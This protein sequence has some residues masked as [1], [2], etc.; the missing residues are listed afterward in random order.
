L[1]A[2]SIVTVLVILISFKLHNLDED[3]LLSFLIL[4][5]KL[6][7]SLLVVLAS[8]SDVFLVAE[9]DGLVVN[10]DATV[11]TVLSSNLDFA[12]GLGWSNLDSLSI[13]EANLTWLVVIDNGDASLGVLSNKFL[14]GVW[15]IELNEEV[16]IWLPVV[17]ILNAN[18]E[19]LGV[20]TVTE[21]NNAIEWNVVL[22]SF[23][24]AVNGACTHGTGLSLLIYNSNGQR[25]GRL[26]DGVM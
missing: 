26:T 16:L 1:E 14:I 24:I 5:N 10:R 23:G 18:G 9:L 20:L 2:E 6:T 19:R 8:L 22:V 12:L 3:A 11:T 17:I 15:L 7:S 21:F 25:A 4:E 13:L